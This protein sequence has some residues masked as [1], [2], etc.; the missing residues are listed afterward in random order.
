MNLKYK[1]LLIYAAIVIGVSSL[2]VG[3]LFLLPKQESG[4]NY[5]GVVTS[6]C[7]FPANDCTNF[8]DNDTLYAGDVNDIFAYLGKTGTTS[9]STL[10]YQVT[11]TNANNIAYTGTLTI[12]NASTTR[13]SVPSTGFFNLNAT[14]TMQ[15]FSICTAGNGACASSGVS[16]LN[17]QTG[18]L[19]FT[20][21]LF[22]ADTSSL[23]GTSTIGLN[24]LPTNYD[25]LKIFDATTT[26]SFF[27]PFV[28]DTSLTASGQIA[29]NTTSASTSLRF[30]DGTAE[31]A[32][33]DTIEKTLTVASSTLNAAA[34]TGTSTIDLGF[35]M[36]G[37]TWLRVAC[38]TDTG[39][40]WAIFTDGTNDMP[41]LSLS[42]TINNSAPASNNTFTRYEARKVKIGSRA[43]NPN[44][45]TCSILTRLNAD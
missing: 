20:G 14:G 5:L 8:Q 12:T 39:T 36:R 6:N 33:Y 7:N 25:K 2:Y 22:G 17:A 28:A 40:A 41:S 24:Y 26:N 16:S 19:T 32:V 10:T 29:I 23:T 42:S 43:S 13:F 44:F 18:G 37:E 45:I 34:G 38:G 1:E 3:L 35:S 21:F 4:L 15:G 27:I 30:H 31:R 11:N 9:A